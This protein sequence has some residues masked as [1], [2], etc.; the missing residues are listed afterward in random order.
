MEGVYQFGQAAADIDHQA[1]KGVVEFDFATGPLGI[2][3]HFEENSG[4]GDATD[5]VDNNFEAFFPN[6]HGY[7]GWADK[8]GGINSQDTFLEL[9][10]RLS[11]QF[12]LKAQAH[13]F[14]LSNPTGSWYSFN[15]ARV[16]G[17]PDGNNTTTGIGEEIDISLEWSPRK[18][19]SIRLTHAHFIPTGVGK[20]LTA[21]DPSYMT[22][23][24]FLINK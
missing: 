16:V 20:E 4:D 12:K 11:D 18:G 2:K 8:I 17:T 13:H 14:A 23:V 5:D 6:N 24:W 22:Y 10:Y 3:L 19:E 15:G 1:W 7:R 21:G 9:R